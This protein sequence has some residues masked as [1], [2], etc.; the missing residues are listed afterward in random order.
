LKQK[1]EQQFLNWY[2]G[3][4]RDWIAGRQRN[5]RRFRGAAGVPGFSVPTSKGNV[6]RR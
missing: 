5:P 4:E 3:R 2:F 6:T 1:G